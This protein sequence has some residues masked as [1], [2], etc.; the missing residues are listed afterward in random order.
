MGPA[1][2]LLALLRFLQDHWSQKVV[3]KP[4][5]IKTKS[6]QVFHLRS[7]TVSS[8][9][10]ARVTVWDTASYTRLRRNRRTRMKCTSIFRV[11]PSL[12]EARKSYRSMKRALSS[13]RI[14][15]GS[16]IQ[17][18]RVNSVTKSLSRV[19]K[20]SMSSLV[21][22]ALAPMSHL[23]VG[24]Q[25]TKRAKMMGLKIRRLYLYPRKD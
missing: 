14:L 12:R 21:V 5:P 23:R 20:K 22:V 24:T 17:T 16:R 6:F 1:Q 7:Q 9:P 13:P 19:G 3:Q 11:I 18:R 15:A 4:S 2:A 8:I 25:A 10:K